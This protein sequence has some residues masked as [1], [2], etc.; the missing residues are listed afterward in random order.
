MSQPLLSRIRDVGVIPVIRADSAGT[1]GA[2]ASALAEAGLTIIEITMTVPDA[3]GAIK[4]AVRS[5]GSE[6]VIGAGT[7]TTPAMAESAI[8]AGATFLVTPG[9][10]PAVIETARRLGTPIIAGALTPTEITAAV[11]AGADWIKVFPASA[12]GGPAYLRALRGPF[13]SLDL[14]PTGGVSLDSVRDYIQAGV[15]AVGVGG[16]I[17][18]R[19]LVRRRDFQLIGAAGRQFLEAVRTARATQT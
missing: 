17:V 12:V 8:D 15:A 10:V 3:I 14:V 13:P 1:A 16:E 6:T 11:D 4:A 5:L 7:V 19:D 2:I 18:S 9:L